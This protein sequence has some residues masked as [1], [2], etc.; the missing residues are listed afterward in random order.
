MRRISVGSVSAGCV[1]LYLQHRKPMVSSRI[2]GKWSLI[3]FPEYV[4]FSGKSM[5][6]SKNSVV[7]A[8]LKQLIYE[9]Y[10][11]EDESTCHR[12]FVIGLDIFQSM[13]ST[14]MHWATLVEF[15]G[16]C[17]WHALASYIRM[18]WLPRS[19]IS[20]SLCSPSGSGHSLSCWSSLTMSTWDFQFGIHGW[21]S[22]SFFII[23][24]H[25]MV[26]VLRKGT[27]NW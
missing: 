7:M 22:S 21:G 4:S 17:W 9:L 27:C 8:S 23:P 3:L 13:E 26:V 11:G 19:S 18:Q 14:V 16:P 2:C 15:L 10:Y 20:S 12:L 25:E 5:N 24:V 1:S 6:M